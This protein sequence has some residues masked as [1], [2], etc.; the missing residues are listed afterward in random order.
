MTIHFISYSKSTSSGGVQTTIR[1][2][3]RFLLAKGVPCQELYVYDYPDNG[4]LLPE[5][6]GST[7]VR[8]GNTPYIGQRKLHLLM[9]AATGYQQI[10]RTVSDGDTLVLFN[11]F[12]LICLPRKILK[13]TRV[14]LVQTNRFDYFLGGIQRWAFQARKQYIDIMT[15]YTDADKATLQQL[16]PDAPFPI[17]VIPRACRLDRANSTLNRSTELIYIGRIHEQHKNLSGLFQVMDTLGAPYRLSIYGGGSK[18]ELARLQ[19]QIDLRD[20]VR[21]CGESQDVAPALRAHGV[22]LMTSHFEGFGNT[23]I[24]ARSQGLPIVAYDTFEALHWIVREGQNGHV[25]PPYDHRAFADAILA[26][27]ADDA[28]YQRYSE[29]ALALADDT[30]QE[31]I[32]ARWHRLLV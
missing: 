25:I 1:G 23:L 5:L 8:W 27:T 6:V 26:I 17:E 4:N 24:E 19:R 16:V 3:Q 18:E 9:A 11:P 29:A 7:S 10:Q 12:Y 32:L 22:F 31:R 21:Y 30:D 13:R 28:T 20:N 2:L 15:V 14:V